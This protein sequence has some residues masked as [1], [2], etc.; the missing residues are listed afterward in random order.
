[1]KPIYIPLLV[2]TF[3]FSTQASGQASGQ[4]GGQPDDGEILAQ[5][6]K[7]VVTQQAF[8]ARADKIPAAMRRATLRDG[9]RF[10]DL[11][12]AMLLQ[13]QLAEDARAAGFDQREIIQER[14]RLAAQAELGQAWLQYYVTSQPA[15]D[16]EAL[17]REYYQLHQDEMLSEPKIDVSQILISTKDR[18]DAEA[19]ELAAR[20][21]QKLVDN[22][23]SFDALV[24]QYS[25]DPSASSN[26]GVFKGVSQGDMV[27]PFE[28]AAFALS[29]GEISRPVKTQY[30]YHIIRLDAHIPAVKRKFS[31]VKD[32]LIAVERERHEA[33]IKKDYVSSL[34]SLDALMTEAA[35]KE[36]IRRQFGDDA[37][38]PA[39]DGAESE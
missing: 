3:I 39:V 16:Y 11:I 26:H 8:A 4:A 22:P 15:A 20:V 24:T 25:E 9:N 29:E 28:Q 32:Q 31:E 38:D 23:A 17:A 10:R 13:A 34:T 2:I 5:R 27:K 37:V 33:R 1:M 18:S 30:G 12:N 36:M 21:R 7:G 35:L 6:G 14:M 19:K